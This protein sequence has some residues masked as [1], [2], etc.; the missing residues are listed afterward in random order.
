MGLLRPVVTGEDGKPEVHCILPDWYF[1]NRFDLPRRYKV[2]YGGR[3]SSK[4]WTFA[5][6]FVAESWERPLRVAV[7]REFGSNL[8]ISAKRAIEGA[9]I[10]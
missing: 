5:R 2:A 8:N 3:G 6:H 9:I 7:C 1:K 10:Q 4:T